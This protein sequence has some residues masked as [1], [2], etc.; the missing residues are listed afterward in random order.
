[1]IV[2]S[3]IKTNKIFLKIFKPQYFYDLHVLPEHYVMCY[4][5][6]DVLKF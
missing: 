4:E 6:R 3:L 1:M 5:L 2:L